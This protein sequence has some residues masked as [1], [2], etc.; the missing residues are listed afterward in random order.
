MN[1]EQ[2]IEQ[3][4]RCYAGCA[5][6]N[7]DNREFVDFVISALRAQQEREKGCTYCMQPEIYARKSQLYCDM[8]G[9]KL[10][11]EK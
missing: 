5:V 10:E 11:V 1:T 9:R 7:S 8:C 6:M 3:M 2:A 4:E